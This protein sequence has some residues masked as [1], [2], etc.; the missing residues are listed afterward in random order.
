MAKFTAHTAV[1][2]ESGT[3]FF[4]PGDDVP[5]WA[6]GKV[7]SHVTDAE[8]EAAEG[9]GLDFTEAAEDPEATSED[10]AAESEFIEADS[11]TAEAPTEGPDFTAPA[12]PR[13]GRPRKAS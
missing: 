3:E 8:S 6:E 11:E 1:H 9:K 2:R 10:S 5:E 12:K 7:G 4:A 13:R